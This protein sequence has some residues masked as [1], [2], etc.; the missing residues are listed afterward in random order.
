MEIPST[1]AISGA[2]SSSHAAKISTSRSVAFI[3]F[4]ASMTSASR[5]RR[6]TTTSGES[7]SVAAK[8][9]TFL[10]S[11]VRQ[12]GLSWRSQQVSFTAVVCKLVGLLPV[13]EAMLV[14]SRV[15]Q[16]GLSW[17]SQREAV[18]AVV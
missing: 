17:R 16:P 9:D 13:G 5:S 2:L 15:R 4:K 14:V 7:L 18:T 12:E 1:V 6:I 8:P 10:V 3:P 11:R